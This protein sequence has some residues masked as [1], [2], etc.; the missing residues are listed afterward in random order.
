MVIY[1]YIGKFLNNFSSPYVIVGF[2]L[3]LFVYNMCIYFGALT[4]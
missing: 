3:I 2:D 1:I 4:E